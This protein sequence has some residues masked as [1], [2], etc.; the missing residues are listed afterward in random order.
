MGKASITKTT[1]KTF[2]ILQV[3]LDMLTF[4]ES[5]RRIR[6]NFR[7]TG[8]ECYKC[9]RHFLDNEKISL[10]ITDKGNKVVCHDCGS[11]IKQEL[12]EE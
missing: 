3:E 2:N 5:F 12:E 4:D 11:E 7:Y 10:I 6:Q 8:F 1:T 9:G